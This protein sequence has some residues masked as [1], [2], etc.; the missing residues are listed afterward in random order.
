MKGDWEPGVNQKAY[1][2]TEDPRARYNKLFNSKQEHNNSVLDLHKAQ[3]YGTGF[4]VE[5]N[6]QSS[7]TSRRNK[8]CDNTLTTI[9]SSQII[10]KGKT[11]NKE[12]IE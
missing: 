10:Q 12:I 5:H 7:Q 2:T 8:T 1:V 3:G 9:D 4:S 11:I 6:K